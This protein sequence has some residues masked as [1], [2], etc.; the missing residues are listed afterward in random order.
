MIYN[1][2][3]FVKVNSTVTPITNGFDANSPDEAVALNQS[4]GSDNSR[5]LKVDMNVQ[6][7]SRATSRTASRRLIQIVYNLLKNRFRIDLPAITVDGEVFPAV[8]AYQ[9]TPLQIPG[10]IGTD[11]NGL[12]MWSVNFQVTGGN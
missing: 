7:L 2:S 10:Y 11:D 5:G 1:L 3:E 12:H 8:V 6:F 4:G 9:I